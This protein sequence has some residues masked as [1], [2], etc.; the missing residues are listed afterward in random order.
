[1]GCRA[2]VAVR[3]FTGINREEGGREDLAAARINIAT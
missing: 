1:V 2:R 3:V